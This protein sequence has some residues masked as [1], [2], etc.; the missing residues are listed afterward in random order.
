MRITLVHESFGGGSERLAHWCASGAA[1]LEPDGKLDFPFQYTSSAVVFEADTVF[2][3]FGSV[4]DIRDRMDH[5]AAKRPRETRLDAAPSI[6]DHANF[7]IIANT[8][9]LC[10]SHNQRVKRFIQN[11]CN[12][13]RLGSSGYHIIG[14]GPGLVDN[15]KDAR[16]IVTTYLGRVRHHA[17]PA[18]AALQ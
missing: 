14:H 12:K 8:V 7:E 6:S 9:C 13:I 5:I 18:W 11:I 1:W 10:A 2:D 17:P 3:S 15:E 16:G 4:C